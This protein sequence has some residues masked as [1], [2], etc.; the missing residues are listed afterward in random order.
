MTPMSN[1]ARLPFVLLLGFVL[2]ACTGN[3]DSTTDVESKRP[4]NILL[5][6]ADDLGYSDIKET[7][8]PLYPQGL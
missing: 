5:I 4:P 6:V 8:V 7:L 3:T 1:R 2:T